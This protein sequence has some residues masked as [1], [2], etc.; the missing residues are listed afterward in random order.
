[1]YVGCCL[2]EHAWDIE[3]DALTPSLP[4]FVNFLR[5]LIFLFLFLSVNS[6][7]SYLI[8]TRTQ[9]CVVFCFFFLR[10][11]CVHV[12]IFLLLSPHSNQSFQTSVHFAAN[13]QW[14][15]LL[16]LSLVFFCFVQSSYVL[17]LFD[18]SEMIKTLHISQKQ[19]NVFSSSSSFFF[20]RHC[21]CCLSL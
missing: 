14:T 11:V 2:V 3:F 12:N 20:V 8:T 21:V 16:L 15:L 6:Y 9:S 13:R 17:F 19:N 7:Y 4:W 5:A 18:C 1:M 10:N